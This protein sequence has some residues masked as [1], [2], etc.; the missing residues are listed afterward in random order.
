L[1]EV[2]RD[3]ASL[4]ERGSLKKIRIDRIHHSD[5]I[6]SYYLEE[7]KLRVGGRVQ[8]VPVEGIMREG[9]TT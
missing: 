3:R 8:R 9:T 2:E 5:L 1:V 7:G 6:L 4:Q